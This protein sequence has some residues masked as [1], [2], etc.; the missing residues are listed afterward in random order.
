M[1]RSKAFHRLSRSS[2]SAA[3][4]RRDRS[5]GS[6]TTLSNLLRMLLF[7]VSGDYPR[8]PAAC[9][10]PSSSRRTRPKA[11]ARDVTASAASMTSGEPSPGPRRQAYHPRARGCRLADG[12]A[13]TE[14]QGH[15]GDPRI[16][17]GQALARTAEEGPR[18]DIVSPTNS[19]R[20]RFM[21]D[22]RQRK[23][24]ARSSER[25]SQAIRGPLQEPAST[26]FPCRLTKPRL[27]FTGGVA[28]GEAAERS[29]GLEGRS[30][31]AVVPNP[32]LA[33]MRKW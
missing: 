12:L 28:G 2:S 18:L 24:G 27:H 32:L 6:V 10:M 8:G 17:C 14:P 16:R 29:N 30:G 7:P 33:T 31:P 20:S 19:P 15:P 26:H 3:R 9:S 11:R 13:G 1:T 25:K 23:R 5:V 22:I 21:R 4:R